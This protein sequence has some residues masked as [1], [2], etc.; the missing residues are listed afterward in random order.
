MSQHQQAIGLERRVHQ[1]FED[2]RASLVGLGGYNIGIVLN[3]SEGGMAILSTEDLD[4]YSLRN[5]RFQAPEFEHWMEITLEIAW[6]S[7]SR[8]QAGI[9]FKGLSEAARIQL[10]AGIAIATVRARQAGQAK[11]A[12]ITTERRE[13]VTDSLPAWLADTATEGRQDVID[14]IPRSSAAP[15]TTDSA[16]A[17]V[18]APATPDSVTVVASESENI[19]NK[20]NSLAEK[21]G[22]HESSLR[23]DVRE[24]ATH[25]PLPEARPMIETKEKTISSKE[26][27][28]DA[29]AQPLNSA[30]TK[31]QKIPAAVAFDARPSPL[32]LQMS[33]VAKM[34]SRN[35][36]TNSAIKQPS[37]ALEGISARADISYGKWAVVGAIAIVASLLAFLVGW[38]LGDPSAVKLG[39]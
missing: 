38:L 31:P 4:L 7:D 2:V 39:H 9:R 37:G 14:P 36:F 20:V 16:P 28:Q 29:P 19:P 10:R 33:A 23:S 17:S 1:R 22:E 21:F 8:K 13:E 30:D 6:I 35:V 32:P 3:I 5:L 11:Q 27:K 15:A 34:P 24:V 12:A 18:A 25:S 26:S